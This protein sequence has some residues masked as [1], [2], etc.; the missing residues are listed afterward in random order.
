[1][2]LIAQ[3]TGTGKV[4]NCTRQSQVLLPYQCQLRVPLIPYLHVQPCY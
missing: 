2:G 4:S 3:V 1:M